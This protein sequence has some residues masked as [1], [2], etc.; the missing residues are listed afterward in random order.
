MPII[1]PHFFYN[2]SNVCKFQLSVS[3]LQFENGKMIPAS[4]YGKEETQVEIDYTSE[5]L[6][7]AQNIKVSF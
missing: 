4:N 3:Q 1:C 5:E 2:D 6:V 7:W